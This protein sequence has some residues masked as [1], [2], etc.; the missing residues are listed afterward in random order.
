MSD[1]TSQIECGRAAT[2]VADTLPTEGALARLAARLVAGRLDRRLADGAAPRPGSMLA[3]HARRLTSDEEREGLARALRT[4]VTDAQGP[5]VHRVL[6]VPVHP[7]G[8]LAAR[9]VIEDIALRLH[10]PRPVRYTAIARLRVL[11]ADGRGPLYR[12]GARGSLTAELK[13]VLARM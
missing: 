5:S 12:K 13:A 6:R 3:A 10:A 4:A 7:A 1:D 2:G 8:V 9:D 11:M